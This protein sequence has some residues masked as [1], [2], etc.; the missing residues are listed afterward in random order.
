MKYDIDKKMILESGR[1]GDSTS[2]M[3]YIPEYLAKGFHKIIDPIKN[4]MHEIKDQAKNFKQDHS[5]DG[6]IS[7]GEGHTRNVHDLDNY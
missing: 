4:R 5:Q 1:F 3:H 2:N 7:D 6:V